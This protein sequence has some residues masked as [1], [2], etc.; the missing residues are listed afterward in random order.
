MEGSHRLCVFRGLGFYEECS[1]T[2]TA[3]ASPPATWDKKRSSI[4]CNHRLCFQGLAI[5]AY[6]YLTEPHGL[7]SCMCCRECQGQQDSRCCCI[8]GLD[9]WVAGTWRAVTLT[10]MAAFGAC[11]PAAKPC[12]GAGTVTTAAAPSA[13]SCSGSLQ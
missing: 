5:R 11:A 6:G 8:S 7:G 2:C 10:T 4:R 13:S 3:T 9:H 1:T 12:S